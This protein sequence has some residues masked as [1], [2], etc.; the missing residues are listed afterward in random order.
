MDFEML[1]RLIK[2][3][4]GEPHSYSGRGMYGKQCVGV[5]LDKSVSHFLA[6]MLDSLDDPAYCGWLLR[7][8]QQDQMGRG[9]VVYWPEVAWGEDAG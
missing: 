2:D 8:A 4:G 1:C 6:D 9:I 3:A 7:E 5:S